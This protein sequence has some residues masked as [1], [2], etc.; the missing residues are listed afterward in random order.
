MVDVFRAQVP[1]LATRVELNLDAVTFLDLGIAAM[2]ERHRIEAARRGGDVRVVNATGMPLFTL[3]VLGM[4]ELLG[5]P[6]GQFFYEW[7]G[8]PSSPSSTDD[9]VR[10]S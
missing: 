5:L 1:S 10:R 8:S 6:P 3:Q 2:L 9:L 4:S 7:I